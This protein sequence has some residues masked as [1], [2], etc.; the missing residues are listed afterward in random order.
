MTIKGEKE[1]VREARKAMRIQ[2]G[3]GDG[4]GMSTEGQRVGQG[5]EE[6]DKNERGW[7]RNSQ[8]TIYGRVVSK[9]EKQGD[10]LEIG[11]SGVG[12]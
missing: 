10:S 3:P 12:L 9:I 5:E 2:C 7:K 11:P 6:G 4:H 8:I 1:N